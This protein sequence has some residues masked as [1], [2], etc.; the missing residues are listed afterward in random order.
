[1]NRLNN[2]P[3]SNRL[4]GIRVVVTGCGYKPLRHTFYDIVTGEPSHD[5]I[6]V[7]DQEMKTNIG[8]ATSAVLARNGATVHMVSTS[9][10]KL[11]NLK[12]NLESIAENG[13]I[14]FSVVDLMSENEVKH[15]ATSLPDNK[16]IYWVQSI[17]LG[18]GA[19]KVQ[20]DNPYLPID[21]IDPKLMEAELSITAATQTMMQAM[22]PIF[23]EQDETRISIITSM[24]AIRA[25][26]LGGAHSTAKAALDKWANSARLGLYKDNIFVTT[27]RPGG[28]DTGMYDNPIVQEAV[29]RV[30]DE[31]AGQYREH[32]TY[33]EPTVVG[34]A[35]N[36]ALTAQAHFPSINIVAKGQF[37]HEG[38]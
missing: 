21:K 37:P 36:L 2:I 3:K 12:T 28:V 7:D 14:E 33:M 9:P 34:E 25:Y 29:N 26:S 27:I 22:L 18:A 31:F 35:V 4:E 16:P 20:D 38:S 17:G 10:E 5:P 30:S 23:K 11:Q 6:T 19:Y 1:M 13:E 15:F 8:S 32:Q 24:S